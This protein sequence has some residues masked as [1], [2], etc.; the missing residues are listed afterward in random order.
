MSTS[1]GT[2]AAP[3]SGGLG[4]AEVTGPFEHEG[5]TAFLLIADP[6]PPG[7]LGRKT[8]AYLTLSEA[9][10]TG[11]AV[12]HETGDVNRLMIEV[13]GDR[14]V[15]IQ[16]GDV[17]KGGRQDRTLA[18]DAILTAEMGRMPIA[19]YC[20]ESGRWS[21]RGGE[22]AERFSQSL[23][24][25]AGSPMKKSSNTAFAKSE[26]GKVWADI[27]HTMDALHA[28][29]GSEVADTASPSSFQLAMESQ[30]MDTSVEPFMK[31]L[32]GL[33]AKDD[34]SVGLA[35]A[36]DGKLVAADVYATP[37]LF[38]ACYRGLL[39]AAVVETLIA[40]G[41]SSAASPDTTPDQ[42]SVLAWLKSVH[43]AELK[44]ARQVNARTR[45]AAADEEKLAV[46]EC[47]DLETGTRVHRG[48]IAE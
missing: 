38:S 47:Q 12:L 11:A 30:R 15:F 3:L 17:V 46:Y 25:V 23:H 14:P 32:G 35:Y 13:K 29:I 5:L 22:S 28:S 21:R 27:S 33:P 44:E 7:D 45:V 37:E 6:P 16:S 36:I 40:R 8:E 4:I 42:N 24:R 18:T 41:R 43:E 1:T 2:A 26:Q 48:Y 34:R 9:L 39:R 31:A 19:A 10:E 20:V